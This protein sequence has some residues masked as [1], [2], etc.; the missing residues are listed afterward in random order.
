MFSLLVVVDV[1]FVI[2]HLLNLLY[3]YFDRLPMLILASLVLNICILFHNVYG[4]SIISTTL[5]W[6]HCIEMGEQ[7]D[8]EASFSCHRQILLPR[9]FGCFWLR[10]CEKFSASNLKIIILFFSIHV[11]TGIYFSYKNIN[12]STI[13]SIFDNS[14]IWV[15][16][17]YNFIR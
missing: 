17:S 2:L 14:Y 12:F 1:I 6:R 7:G 4:K 3:T 11:F 8:F 16:K 15:T 13:L 9:I 10:G 5:V